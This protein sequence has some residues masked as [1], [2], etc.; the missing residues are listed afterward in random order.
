MSW[1]DKK[2]VEVIKYIRD[3][4]KIKTLVETGTFRGINAQLHSK[5]FDLVLTCE[6]NKQYHDS[7]GYRLFK[8]PNVILALQDSPKFLK[9]LLKEKYIFYL[10]AHF[11]NS[12]IPKKDRFVVLKELD[13]MKKF[14][15]SIIIIHDFS[16]GLGHITY[17]GIELDMDLVRS[18]LKKINKKF[19]FYTNKL[20]SCDIVTPISSD[21]IQSGLQIDKET[22]SNL[23]YAW[24][25]PRL[26]YRG[27]LYCLPTKLSD[28]EIKLLGL[29]KWT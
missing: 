11:Y 12:K 6:N 19:H 15:D 24:T 23:D 18:R 2:A 28:K 27:L 13:N 26:T 7:A 10:D 20:E 14:K 21:I 9:S 8:C 25:T 3:K 22:L 29:R 4:Y 1:T 17:D 16:N 5:N